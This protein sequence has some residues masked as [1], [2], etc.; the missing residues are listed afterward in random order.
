[1]LAPIR[2]YGYF[3]QALV[4]L[5]LIGPAD[6]QTLNR[7][8]RLLGNRYA[9]DKAVALSLSPSGGAIALSDRLGNH[10]YV[11]DTDGNLLWQ[12]GDNLNLEHPAAVCLLDDNELQFTLANRLT[13]FKASSRDQTRID[14]L[15]DLAP[16][17]KTVKGLDHLLM[18]SK[19][20]FV[21]LDAGAGQ[22]LLFDNS[23]KLTKVIAASGQGKGHLR[24]PSSI[25]LDF[26]GNAI[27]GDY[28]NFSVQAVSLSGAPLFHAGWNR[29]GTERSW[30]CSAVAVDRQGAIWAADWRERQWRLFDRTGAEIAVRPFDAALQHPIA[31]VFTADNRMIVLEERGA[32]LLYDIP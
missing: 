7:E 25:A 28:R 13:V 20:D 24:E 11:I 18:T 22:L 6:G 5:C 23:W 21:A 29:P 2:R 14:T 3:V 30:E 4:V 32:A 31:V 1:M 10:L 8:L 27:V 19:G 9:L 12:V 26:A 17:V 15:A 16:Y